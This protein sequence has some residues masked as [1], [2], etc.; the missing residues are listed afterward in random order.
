MK[1][2]NW[3]VV[4]KFNTA[5]DGCNPFEVDFHFANEEIRYKF[6]DN[7]SSKN[8]ETLLC[9]LDGY[10]SYYMRCVYNACY[11]IDFILDKLFPQMKVGICY[12][13][14]GEIV[15]MKKK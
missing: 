6:Q 1:K 9:I 12:T 11:S 15:E 10:G 8:N 5:F 2:S 7:Y 3:D 4:V 13:I 14:N